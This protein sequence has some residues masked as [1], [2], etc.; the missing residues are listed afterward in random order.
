MN[1]WK[2][3]ENKLARFIH[4]NSCGGKSHIFPP[5]YFSEQFP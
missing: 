5:R 2:L 4:A 3:K 1:P